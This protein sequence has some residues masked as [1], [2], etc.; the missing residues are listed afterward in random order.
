M[1]DLSWRPVVEMAMLVLTLGLYAALVAGRCWL[2]FTPSLPASPSIQPLPGLVV[3]QFMLGE[4][5]H[6]RNISE[7]RTGQRC[8]HA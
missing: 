3:R 2:P 8:E 6:M 7:K 5:R 4:R 1:N